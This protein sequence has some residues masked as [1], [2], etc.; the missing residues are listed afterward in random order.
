MAGLEASLIYTSLEL[1]AAAMEGFDMEACR[2]V[3]TRTYQLWEAANA[4][5]KCIQKLIFPEGV[6]STERRTERYLGTP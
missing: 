4:D 1:R 6:S 5:Q 3:K 2:A